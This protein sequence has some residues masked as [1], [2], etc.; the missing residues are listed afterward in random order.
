M[1]GPAACARVAAYQRFRR[2]RDR[3]DLLRR[4]AP[5]RCPRWKT[6]RVSPGAR[7]RE[8][9]G[10]D[11]VTGVRRGGGFLGG[12]RRVTDPAQ[13]VLRSVTGG[14]RCGTRSSA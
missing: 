13:E 5:R 3:P 7:G 8:M 10:G 9:G 4:P 12:G 14:E 6:S 1:S 11:V 2:P